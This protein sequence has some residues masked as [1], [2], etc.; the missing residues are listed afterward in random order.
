MR[1]NNNNGTELSKY[2]WKLKD[3]NIQYDINWKIRHKSITIRN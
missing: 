1:K 3:K 2:I